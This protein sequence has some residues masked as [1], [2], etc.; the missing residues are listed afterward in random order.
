MGIPS[1]APLARWRLERAGIINIYQ[2]GDEVLEF[3]GGRLLLRGV[4]GSGKSTAMNMLLPFLLTASQRNIDAA[5]EQ[6]GLLRSWMLDGR[7]D[8][9]PVGYLWIEFRLG[10]EYFVCGCGIKANRQADNVTTWWFATSKRPGIDFDLVDGGV[11]LSADALRDRLGG[12]P[13]FARRDR[14]DY[15]SHIEQ[16]LFGG[17]NLDQHIRLIDKVRNPRVG[18]RI[19]VDLPLDLADALPQLSEQALTD[20][21]A[22]LDDL[23]DHRRNVAELGRTITAVEGLLDR[24]RAYCTGDLRQRTEQGRRLLAESQRNRRSEVAARNAVTAA[25]EEAERLDGTIAAQQRSVERL[26]SEVSAIEESRAYQEGRQ[27]DGVRDLVHSLNR[28]HEESTRS[29]ANAQEQVRDS[30]EHLVAAA[31]RSEDDIVE[32]NSALSQADQLA[33]RCGVGQRPPTAVDCDRVRLEGLEVPVPETFDASSAK[34]RLDASAAGA[35]QRRGDIDRVAEA[36]SGCD[37]SEAQYARATDALDDV[38]NAKQRASDAHSQRLDALAAAQREWI[39]RSDDWASAAVTLCASARTQTD[40]AALAAAGAELLG[41]DAESFAAQRAELVAAFDAAVEVQTARVADGRQALESAR[42]AAA[43]QQALVERLLGMSE[44]ESPRLDW[45]AP[46]DHCFAD[47]VDFLPGLD[48]AERVGIEA[49]LE[50]SGLLAARMHAEDAL[51]LASGEL[52]AVAASPVDVPLS[53]W[54]RPAMPAGLDDAVDEGVVARL[55]LSISGDVSAGAAAAAPDG[56]FRTGLLHGRHAKE[57]AELIGAAARREALE[58]KRADAQRELEALQAHERQAATMLERQQETLIAFRRHGALLPDTGAIER[59]VGG[60]EA[61]ASELA[62]AESRHEEAK[63]AA[64]LAESN[65]NAADAE[66][67]RTASTLSLPRDRAGLDSIAAE[68]ADFQR[69]LGSCNDGLTTLR[70]SVDECARAAVQYGNDLARRDDLSTQVTQTASKRD[71]EQARLDTLEKTVG[72]DYERVRR[73]RDRLANEFEQAEQRLPDMREQKE[74]T[75]ERRASARAV[76]EHAQQ[77][78]SISERSCETYRVG[79][80]EVIRIQGYFDAVAS[81]EATPPASDSAGSAGLAAMLDEIGRLVPAVAERTAAADTAVNADSVRQSLQQRRGSLGAGWDAAALQPDASN[82]LAVE[83]TG[84]LGTM[85]LAAALRSATSQHQQLAG[86]LDRKQQD[87]LR[88]LLQGLIAREIAQKMRGAERLIE[89]TNERL[90]TVSTAHRVG[91]RLRWR[92]SPELDDSTARMVELLAKPP[93]LRTPD[94]NSEVRDALTQRL[95]TARSDDPD[96]PYRQLIAETLD[97]KTWHDLDVMVTRP[98]APERRLSRRTPLSEGEKKL[99]TYLPLFVAVAASYDVLAEA[100]AQPGAESPQIAR[101][102][103]LDDAFAKVSADNH[104]SLF[105]LLVSLDLD[106]IATSERLWGDHRTV[107]E[108]SIVEIVRDV[109]LKSILLDRYTWQGDTLER[110]GMT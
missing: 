1:D 30:C 9:Q 17:A 85:T 5:R 45:Q 50:A 91:V 77:A 86:L 62:A 46:A 98:E 59:V 54:L 47:L 53:R 18:D 29:L 68:L 76:A 19:D 34:R 109:G 7:D 107:P 56:S 24:Y 8:A 106:F 87:A 40:V 36:R 22:P 66:L 93:D 72:A 69:L 11:P 97:Y 78:A 73:E 2:Y 21:A 6:S 25:E 82:P 75:V 44:P 27:L 12:D 67:R 32:L 14:R 102:V 60:L 13:V 90:A 42:Q 31:G 64:A 23:E 110:V 37:Q 105:G 3:R 71:Q 38:A 84:P 89:R 108:L 16:R 92:R 96:A 83:V 57:R 26:R 43:D 10:N 35:L 55:L 28:Q 95:D 94:E 49:A 74:R 101:F 100:G 104:A 61:A 103:L 41:N 80:D 70:R 33:T 79:I 15:K 52:V 51:E 88:E 39:G 63:H 58:R 65:V 99:V 4:N 20:A 81:Q 48:E